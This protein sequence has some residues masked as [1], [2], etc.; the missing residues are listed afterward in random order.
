MTKNSDNFVCVVCDCLIL[1]KDVAAHVENEEKFELPIFLNSLNIPQ[2]FWI[3]KDPFDFENIAFSKIV[4]NVK[5][6]SCADCNSG[7]LGF[8]AEGKENNNKIYLA[9]DRIKSNSLY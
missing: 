1:K 6:L 9:D 8:Y 5:Y 3:V 2:G 7:P 4:N